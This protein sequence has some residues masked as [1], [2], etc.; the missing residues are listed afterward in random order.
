MAVPQE[1]NPSA[2]KMGQEQF[3]FP[4]EVGGQEIQDGWAAGWITKG[5]QW[6]SS[7]QSTEALPSSF[8]KKKPLS[9]KETDQQVL[10]LDPTS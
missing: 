1:I 4:M 6:A 3:P 7:P 2:S 8:L 9:S 5:G 10:K